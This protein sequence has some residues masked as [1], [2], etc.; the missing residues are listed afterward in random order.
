MTTVGY[1]RCMKALITSGCSVSSMQSPDVIKTWPHW[2]EQHTQP[3][4]VVH[5]GL[6]S[7]GTDLIS[8]K[9]IYHCT[10]ALE[11]YEAKDILLVCAYSTLF[12]TSCLLNHHDVL[13][14]YL[15][16]QRKEKHSLETWKYQGC[17]YDNHIVV[18][19]EDDMHGNPG[20]FYFNHWKDNTLTDNYYMYYQTEYSMMEQYLWNLNAVENFCAVNNINY[21][22]T[23]IDDTLEKH[24]EFLDHWSMK[25]LTDVLHSENRITPSIGDSVRKHQPWMMMDQ[26]HP[27]ELAHQWYV[28]NVML[29]HLEKKQYV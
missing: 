22:W 9:A 19:E 7:T 21:V 28:Q 10:K 25:H 16:Q 4:H 6:S 17:D 26:L 5:S 1:R 27:S 12:R 18:S 11:Q 13:A 14:R 29:P 3:E 23:T 8:K 20:W 15:L 2:L 24:S